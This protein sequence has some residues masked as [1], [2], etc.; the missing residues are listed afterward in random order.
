M[1]ICNM[2]VWLFCT[3]GVVCVYDMG[4]MFVW[5]HVFPTTSR[6]IQTYRHTFCQCVCWPKKTQTSKDH[7][8]FLQS[9]SGNL[10]QS[11]VRIT[12][13]L[14]PTP[15]EIRDCMRLG[16]ACKGQLNCMIITDSPKMCPSFFTSS[17]IVVLNSVQD[18]RFHP[19]PRCL[20]CTFQHF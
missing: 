14:G 16:Y 20:P 13:Y 12:D 8:Y 5:L 9:L 1:R 19:L 15:R 18:N 11:Y 4:L 3:K 2:C 10:M 6:I 7:Q 17:L